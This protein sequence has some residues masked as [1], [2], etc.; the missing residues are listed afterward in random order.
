MESNYQCFDSTINLL[1]IDQLA[2]FDSSLTDLPSPD[3]KQRRIQYL[4]DAIEPIGPGRP[5]MK[6]LESF[7]KSMSLIFLPLALI[8]MFLPLFVVTR[9]KLMLKRR[10]VNRQLTEALAHWDIDKQELDKFQHE[11]SIRPADAVD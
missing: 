2:A 9:F 7:A 1:A 8:F 3:D 4:N 10:A 11:D 5:F 6:S